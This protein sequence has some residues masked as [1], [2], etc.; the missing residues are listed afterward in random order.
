[1]NHI[2]AS[3]VSERGNTLSPITY[4]SKS[5]LPTKLLH[6]TL[7]VAIWACGS[8]EGSPENQPL[9]VSICTRLLLPQM[10]DLVVEEVGQ[11]ARRSLLCYHSLCSML[12]SVGRDFVPSVGV[13]LEHRVTTDHEHQLELGCSSLD[14]HH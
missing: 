9:A 3:A 6:T 5:G 8:S 2:E 12:G 11:V 14:H 7:I 1:M 13:H 4:K 10:C